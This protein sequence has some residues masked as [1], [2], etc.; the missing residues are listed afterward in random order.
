LIIETGGL[1]SSTI[2]QICALNLPSLEHLELWLGSSPYEDNS[3][4]E[5]LTPILFEGIFPNLTYLGLRNSEYA[6]IIASLVVRSPLLE[7]LK[8]LDLSMG[9]LSDY[10]AEILLSSPSVYQLEI[11][12][13]AANC[14]SYEMNSRVWSELGD[15]TMTAN[16]K[17]EDISYRYYSGWE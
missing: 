15:C 12:N 7:Q 9:N 8:V 2:A 13:L 16:Q 6:D 10:G 17:S 11:L 4:V 3:L 14:L 1:S 5:E